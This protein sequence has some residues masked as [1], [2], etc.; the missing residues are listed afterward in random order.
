MRRSALIFAACALFVSGG[1]W[2]Q[3]KPAAPALQEALAIAPA[4]LD[5]KVAE[6]AERIEGC[7]RILAS[8]KI[9][10]EVLLAALRE[11]VEDDDKNAKVGDVI[12][13]ITVILDF[14][15]GN[16]DLRKLRAV[17]YYFTKQLDP[18]MADFNELARIEP[19]DSFALR[20]RGAV[21]LEKGDADG[22]IAEL[23]ELLRSGRDPRTLLFRGRAFAVK[24][25]YGRALQDFDELLMLDPSNKEAVEL[26]DIVKSELNAKPKQAPA[27]APTR[28]R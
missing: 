10:R 27:S 9:T 8:G 7:K 15:P 19:T 26:R 13:T 17:A 12:S 16:V 20:G 22:A 5:V 14:D 21:L 1:A 24:K 28:G 4:C 23:T 18:A 11:R 6:V 2:S 3:D 25:D